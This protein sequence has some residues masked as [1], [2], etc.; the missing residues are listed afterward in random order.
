MRSQS[1]RRHA[2]EHNI[3]FRN[4]TFS[5]M[6]TFLSKKLDIVEKRC[7]KIYLYLLIV[8]GH[9]KSLESSARNLNFRARRG[10]MFPIS[11][12]ENRPSLFVQE[13]FALHQELLPI[14]WAQKD[15][16]S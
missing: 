13:V 11:E 1:W 15:N 2:A 7:D 6:L 16:K 14:C 12:L 4:A 9:L 10:L 5:S 3:Q 8:D